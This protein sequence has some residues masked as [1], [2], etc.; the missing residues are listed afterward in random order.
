MGCDS[1]KYAIREISEITGVKPVT[2]RAWQRRYSLIQP[3]RTDKGHRLYTQAHVETIQEIQGWLAKGIAIGKVKELLGNPDIGPD[4]DAVPQSLEQVEPMLSA[5][6]QLKSGKVDSMVASLFKDYPLQQ[7]ENLFIAPVMEALMRVKGS[8]RSIQKALFQS[9][10]I[11]RL[12]SIIESENKAAHKGHTL[13]VNLD[14]AGSVYA[15]LWCM[16]VA[17]T[18]QRITM[19]DGVD[20]ASGLLEIGVT[21]DQL[22]VFSN[23]ALPEA[24][25]EVIHQLKQLWGDKML[26]S[27]M[28]EHLG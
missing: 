20:D 6:A 2:L 22:S 24:T 12:S 27:P 11:S 13:V 28:I 21:F 8:S 14:A 18:G 5:L 26:C 9:V 16:R 1:K 17:E 19:L 15:W 4:P 7:V 25:K 3:E 10:M 23:R